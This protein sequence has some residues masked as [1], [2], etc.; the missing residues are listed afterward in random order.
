MEPAAA[1]VKSAE[2]PSTQQ[3]AEACSILVLHCDGYGRE[4]CNK[5]N[6]QR[7]TAVDVTIWGGWVLNCEESAV[8]RLVRSQRENLR[9]FIYA[10]TRTKGGRMI[11]PHYTDR[12]SRMTFPSLATL[13]YYEDR[14]T[15][16]DALWVV[17]NLK[18]LYVFEGN[19]TGS[20]ILDRWNLDN[21]VRGNVR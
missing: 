14:N 4:I 10:P 21:H 17:P 1:Q 18:T 12:S 11:R 2:E 20:C 8:A 13:G 19:V 3:D 16:F 15:P 6:E 7:H 5:A 9:R